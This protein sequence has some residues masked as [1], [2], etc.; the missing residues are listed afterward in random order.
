MKEW[1]EIDQ[2]EKIDSPQLVVF[3]D[4][5]K[6]NIDRAIELV[7]EI[8]R[9]RPHVKT[10]KTAEVM[11]FMLDAGI[12]KFK[13]ATIAE[14]ELLGRLKAPD[15]LLAY[16]PVGP[17]VKRFLNLV[18]AYP[19]TKF[20]CLIDYLETAEKIAD[21]FS[22]NVK[23][24][25]V[26]IDINAGMNR[27]GIKTEFALEL[28]KRCYN[29]RG[30]R[31]KGLHLYDGH[32]RQFDIKERKVACD[33]NFVQ[34][35]NL[36]KAIEDSGFPKPIIIAGGSPTFPIHAQRETVEC[37]P[38]TFV[39][40][41]KTYGDICK[42]QPFLPAAIVVTRVISLPDEGK[43]CIDL[44]HKSIA[45][46]NDISKRVYFL[47]APELRLFSQSEEHGVVEAGANH[48]FKPGDV[49]YILPYHVCPT[50]A[51]YNQMISINYLGEINY[52][53]VKA[54]DRKIKY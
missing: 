4:R 35:T 36:A 16:Q 24:I 21:T 23:D 41:D 18:E 20:S 32:F 1:Y 53:E 31:I 47:N 9:F 49:L 13:C 45:A 42:E 46:E 30:I 27:S 54:R 11:Q 7:G 38:G 19:E 37:S 26:Y 29:L 10:N 43:I 33:V 40:W 12:S 14:A 51:L 8:G 5:V 25:E 3:E 6:Y 52:W 34:L 44:G 48:Q 28:Y 22:E 50:V 17:K 15:V 2:I 39:F